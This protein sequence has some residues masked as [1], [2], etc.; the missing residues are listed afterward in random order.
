[1]AVET[2]DYIV[3]GSGSAGGVVAARL[4]EDGRHRV[5]CLEA[6]A[7]D[8]RYIWT[9]SPLGG[10]FMIEDPKVNWCDYSEANETHG[11]RKLYVAHGKILGGSSAI[12]ATLCNRGQPRDYDT[13]AQMGCRGWG[14]QD[15][16]P[17]F[18]KIERTRLGDDEYRGRDGLV[19]VTPSSKISPFYDLFIKSAQAI[20]L[21]HNPD[22][23][24]PKQYG[25]AMAQ[26]AAL[27]GRR[28]STATQYL[29]PARA[30]RNMTIMLDAHA[31]RLLFEGKR[32]VGV[33][34]QHKG[35]TMVARASQEVVVSSG[36]VNT[37]KLLELSGIGNPDVLSR[38]GIDVIQA[39]PGVGE[40]L[41]D[42]YG[43]TMKWRVS[44]AEISASRQGRG[45]RI[46]R[47]L[48]RYVLFGKGFMSQG[49]GTLR[50]FTKS[51]EAVEDADIQMIANPFIV[52]IVNGRR[53]M[54][55]V[56]GFVVMPQV[57]RPESAGSV[58]I[59]SRDP[60]VPPAINYQF[61]ATENDRRIAVAAVRQARQLVAAP[62][63]ANHIA[64]EMSPGPTVQSDEQIVDYIRNTGGT[65]FHF[66]GTC[67][68]GTDAMSVVDERLRVRGVRGLRIA[69]ASVMPIIVSGNTSI[70]CM[71]IGEK[72]AD[73]IL[74]D[75]RL[76]VV[77]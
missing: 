18:K 9:R 72:C 47:E 22:Y 17:Y 32:C 24:G 55:A 50:V 45:W 51:N 74:S 13:W 29:A 62:P 16:L 60:A 21:P 42:H 59:K 11:N 57:Q 36:C 63:L 43:P 15:I 76:H 48:A 10:A 19:N 67:K 46:A 66:A 65:T 64:E 33:E 12:N 61:L 38:F 41:R 71:M 75:A 69:D 23:M 56:D 40:N 73:M 52:E 77:Q 37:P 2:Y 49:I 58:H 1:M 28:N 70:P 25:V 5:L 34:F 30:R 6:G 53:K 44:K 14:Y 68:M 35:K 39:L 3:V 27:R 8:E 26:Q 7:K 31:S 54:A 20:G 4:A